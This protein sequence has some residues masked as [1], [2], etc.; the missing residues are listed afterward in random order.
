LAKNH[1]DFKLYFFGTQHPNQLVSGMRIPQLAIN[2]SQELGLYNK[3]IFFGDWVPYEQ[4]GAYLGEGDISVITH[5]AHIETH[6]SYR[7]RV[8]DSIWLGIPLIIT[9]GDS[10]S[11]M[12]EGNAIGLTVPP[13]NAEAL[14]EAIEKLLMDFHPEAFAHAFNRLRNE[15]SWDNVIGPLRDF[16]ENPLAAADK[17]QYM[18]EVERISK[19]K[20]AFWGAVVRNREMVIERYQQSLPL[21]IYATLKRVFGKSM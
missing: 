21:R 14:A 1:P 20:D 2:L 13:C 16:C 15:Y 3:T 10:M 7:T 19:D 11:D 9:K 18:T 8:L 4:R 6:F 12:V 5:Q 17:G